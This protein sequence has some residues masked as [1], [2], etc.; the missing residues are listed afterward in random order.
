MAE[1]DQVPER[2]EHDGERADAR[3]AIGRPGRRIRLRR[4][5]EPAGAV[6]PLSHRSAEGH[7]SW[8]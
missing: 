8:H 3:S 1:L 6:C 7:P 2:T 4:K 5:L